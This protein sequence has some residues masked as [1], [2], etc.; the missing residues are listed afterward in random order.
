MITV[1][2]FFVYISD[3]SSTRHTVLVVGYGKEKGVPYW[4][5]KNSWSASWGIDGYIKLA[6]KGNTCGVTKNPVVALMK[7]NTFQFPVK[8]KIKYVNPLDPNSMGRKVHAQ[9]RPGFHRNIK[10]SS[11][12]KSSNDTTNKSSVP[13]KTKPSVSNSRSF[14]NSHEVGNNTEKL[15]KGINSS[16]KK[17]EFYTQKANKKTEKIAKMSNSPLNTK[18]DEP[19]T[20]ELEEFKN[21]DES[22]NTL[23]LDAGTDELNAQTAD[24]NVD[25]TFEISSS[26]PVQTPTNE[27]YASYDTYRRG[28]NFAYYSDTSTEENNEMIRNHE[29]V[30]NAPEE[31]ENVSW[32]LK[33][34]TGEAQQ[35]FNPSDPY[36]TY[37]SYP[38][39]EWDTQEKLIKPPMDT[40]IPYD[41]NFAVQTD[42]HQWLPMDHTALEVDT[43]SDSVQNIVQDSP[44]S[45]Q[46][47]YK[48]SNQQDKVPIWTTSQPTPFLTTM[49]AKTTIKVTKAT[50]K[51]QLKRKVKN[52]KDQLKRKVKNRPVT[53]PPLHITA[54]PV[55]HYSGKLQEIYDKLERVIASSLKKNGRS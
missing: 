46:K 50:P 40:I 13:V 31:T 47:S 26:S 36:N 17:D 49:A 7:H 42:L 21:A 39:P 11:L 28:D 24:D 25:R 5:V 18:T 45:L 19:S 15:V 30:Y 27:P 35:Y 22:V 41:G 44:L 1:L 8:E 3:N 52:R 10:G 37:S 14:L 9:P 54:K 33:S 2:W 32:N 4:L 12:S 6:W 29:S 51:D 16:A 38:V 34:S 20:K 55:R 43:A 23:P 53:T 48:L